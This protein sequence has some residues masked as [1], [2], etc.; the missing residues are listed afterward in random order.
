MRWAE[1]DI[2]HASELIRWVN[3]N[4][5]R[6]IEKAKRFAQKIKDDYSLDVIGNMARDHL[7]GL[8]NGNNT[9]KNVNNISSTNNIPPSP[10]PA[11]WY[12]QDYFDN[13][14]KSNWSD[15]YKWSS[16]AGLFRETADLLCNTFLSAES[17]LDVG[18]AKGF[19]IQTLREKGKIVQGFD[20][21][22]WAVNHAL[23][24][25]RPY[26]VCAGV[27][28][29]QYTRKFDML[30]ALETFSH[31]TE[32]QTRSFLMR[33]KSWIE[34]GLFATI[35][36]FE[37]DMEICEFKKHDKDMS[38]ILLKSQQWWHELFLSTGWKQ[39]RL[40]RMLQDMC[41]EHKLTK[42]MKWSVY[43]YSVGA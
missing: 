24:T 12:D 20:H 25:S 35:P 40:H 16:F 14:K 11:D 26:I 30:L 36:T 6:S 39:D 22:V 42:N 10:I 21:S 8:L 7:L 43:V 28:D 2:H 33:V 9:S 29:V 23:P 27:D 1:P 4:R 41:Q 31:L 37:S 32:S 17:F 19:L 3:D 34:I 38:H 15:G 5:E 13:G 18:C